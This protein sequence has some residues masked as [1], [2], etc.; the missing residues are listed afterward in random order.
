M[1]G[2]DQLFY[3]PDR[4]DRGSPADA[5]LSYENV[6]F[7]SADGTRLH[8]WFMPALAPPAS[9]PRKTLPLAQAVPTTPPLTKGG[10]GG[11]APARG[12]V[13]HVHGNAGNITGHYQ[14]VDWLPQAGYH[15][16]AFDYR[17]YGRSA[18][19]IS[20]DGSIADTFAALD[21]LR[22]R[23]DVDAD[24]IFVLGQSIG[25]S[26][27]I[28]VTAARPGQVRALVVDGAFTRY[29]DI[30]RHHVVRNPPLLILGWWYP[31]TLSHTHDPI[32]AV[33]RISPTPVLFMHGTADRVVPHAM[34]QK[35]YDAAREPKELW[36]IDGMDHYEV[37]SERPEV[38]QRRLLDFFA[39]A[40]AL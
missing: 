28:V 27:A 8:G 37:W 11:V 39:G 16:L 15:V 18:G 40:T 36:L 25:G 35:L 21:Y 24:R 9:E 1:L 33:A 5:G 3:Y 13:L 23:P 20:R 6:W 32:D 38:V 26:I 7:N 22:C 12:A 29:R 17:G 4:R 34:S 2:C 10:Q 31:L 30:A 14:A 19:R